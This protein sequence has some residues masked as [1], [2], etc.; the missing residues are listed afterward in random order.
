[1]NFG[2]IGYGNIGSLISDNLID[3]GFLDKNRLNISSRTLSKLENLDS[4]INVYENNVDLVKDSDII[5]ISVKSPDLIK[6]IGEIA[7]FLDE[8]SYLIHSSAGI[9]FYDIENV[10]DG[11]ISCVIPSIS[12]EANPNKQKTGI[13][14]FYHNTNVSKENQEKIE[15]LFSKFSNVITTDNYDD[16]EALTITT[17][18][19]PAFIAFAT[20]VFA[21]ELSNSTNLDYEDVYS[22]LNETNFSTANLLNLKLFNSDDLVNKVATKNG[23]TQKGLDYLNEELPLIFNNLIKRLCD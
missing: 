20:E 8:D 12:S 10:Y 15:E 4:R 2:I 11:E 18:C 3:I 16:L 6:V 7:P 21:R 14:V 19:M 1:M 23:I 22:Y 5:F 13:S 17:S 9:S